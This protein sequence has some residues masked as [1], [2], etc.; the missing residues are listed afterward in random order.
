MSNLVNRY[1]WE[2]LQE[3][4]IQSVTQPQIEQKGIEQEK[5]LLSLPLSKSNQLSNRRIISDWNLAEEDPVVT[6]EDLEA[7]LQEIRQMFATMEDLNE[8][9]GVV[10]GDFVTLDFAG[11]VAGRI[12]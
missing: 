12:I 1:Y 10:A 9:R 3:K 2:T 11:F 5:I 6:E 8:D 7:R 4:D